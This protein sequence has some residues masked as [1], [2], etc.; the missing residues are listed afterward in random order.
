MQAH[1]RAFLHSLAED[2]GLD[3][4]SQDPEP[5]RHVVIFKTPKFVSAPKKTL[6][7]SL[8]LVKVAPAAAP[9]KPTRPDQEPFNALL[10]T[11]PRFGLTA[12]ELEKALVA[13]IGPSSHK[14]ITFSTSFLSDE[15]L[16]RAHAPLTAATIATSSTTPQAVE[17]VLKTIR[18]SISRKIAADNLAGSVILCTLG[19]TG[20]IVRKEGG[21]TEPGWSAVAGRSAWRPKPAGPAAPEKKKGFGFVALR[22]LG[23][24]KEKVKKEPVVEDWMAEVQKEETERS[25]SGSSGDEDYAKVEDPPVVEA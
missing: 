20:T 3:S 11:S 7:Q 1:Q 23:T 2:F 19:S 24:G 16:I 14:P 12:D 22:K 25:G 21:A 18:P 15:V 13:D 17:N 6:A 4:E 5:H 8:R 9:A 10:L